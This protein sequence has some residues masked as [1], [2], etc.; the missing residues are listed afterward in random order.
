MLLEI[1]ETFALEQNYP[2]PFNPQTKIKFGIPDNIKGS[3]SNVK[4]VVYDMLGRVV[5]TLVDKELKPGNY[6][7]NWDA[8]VYSS[9][10]Y[11]YKL[12]AADFVETKKMV[13][14][15]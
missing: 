5:S 13:L 7:I 6:E 1:P 11:F 8:S 3:R 12:L 4:L 10:V 15:K 14:M 2:N 9:G